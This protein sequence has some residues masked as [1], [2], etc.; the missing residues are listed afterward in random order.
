MKKGFVFLETII[1]IVLLSTSLI[2]I[3]SLTTK[4]TTNIENRK[5]FDNVSDIYKTKIIRE[6]LQLSKLVG[7][8]YLNIDKDNCEIY[9][10]DKCATLLD[11]LSVNR[12]I[13]NF[14]KISII[15]NSTNDFPNSMKEY[16]NTF[17]D[18][19]SNYVIVNFMYDSKN[20]YASLEV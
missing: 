3:Y 4:I 18:S 10:T 8:D 1:V 16:L 15:K 5:Y 11:D 20:Y 13:V 7:N 14:D 17:K 9:M 19:E 6:D 2:G 12:I